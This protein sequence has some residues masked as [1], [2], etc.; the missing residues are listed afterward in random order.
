MLGG[1]I[2]EETGTTQG[3]M[4]LQNLSGLSCDMAFIGT[5][6]LQKDGVLFTPTEEKSVL[7]RRMIQSSG[8]SILVTDGTKYQKGGLYRVAELSDF[9]VCI[10]DI[11]WSARQRKEFT[12]K[13]IR[14]IQVKG[15]E[16]G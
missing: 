16:D 12:E 14:L 4:A 7:K 15:E 3:E 1:Q 8:T 9:D 5:S 6:A 2:N 11:Q 10:T 13:G